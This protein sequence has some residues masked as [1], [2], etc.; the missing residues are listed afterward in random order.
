M[1]IVKKTSA[2]ADENPIENF[3]LD[4]MSILQH[5][6]ENGESAYLYIRTTIPEKVEKVTG[7]FQSSGTPANIAN[8]ILSMMVS[9]AENK[10]A[11]LN[12]VLTYMN[13][14]KAEITIFQMYLDQAKKTIIVPP[15]DVRLH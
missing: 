15:K 8:C 9:G 7:F 1:E 13:A 10:A 5:F 11:V 6:P 2:K 3:D 14:N 4:V 12:A